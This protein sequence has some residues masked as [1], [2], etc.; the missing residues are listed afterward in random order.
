MGIKYYLD[1]AKVEIPR[2]NLYNYFSMFAV[3]WGNHIHFREISQW[4]SEN[5]KP[6]TWH[7]EILDESHLDKYGVKV[8]YFQDPRDRLIFL[9]RWAQ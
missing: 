4:C 2:N 6:G 9:L 7:G 1:W 5:L 8:F 3:E